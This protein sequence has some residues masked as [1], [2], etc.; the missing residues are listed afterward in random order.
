MIVQEISDRLD[1]LLNKNSKGIIINEYFKS[2]YLTQAQAYFVDHILKTYEYGDAIRHILGKILVE[3]T[4]IPGD[5]IGTEDGIQILPL[6][7]AVKQILYERTNDI[8]ETIPLDYNDIHATINNPFRKPSAEI[9]YRNT[10]DNKIKLYTS[11]TFLK[12][13]Y[14]YCKIPGPIILENFPD[15]LSIQGL[16][17]ETESELPYDSI[18]RVIEIASNL[19]YKNKARF[20]QK[21]QPQVNT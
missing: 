5:V 17:V 10:M 8:I 16:G 19:I 20:V 3:V 7:A 1:T 6:V 14:I 21:E 4:N 2:L 18:L 11:E 13:H 9:A 15:N 12:Y